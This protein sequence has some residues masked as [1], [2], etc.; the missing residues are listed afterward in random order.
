MDFSERRK[1]ARANLELPRLGV[2]CAAFGGLYNPVSLDD[3]MGV[4][5]QAWSA[6]I[7][8]F[9]TAPMYG[10][11]RAE[12]LL[13][14]F[15]R[16]CIDDASDTVI[17]T[18]A[19]RLMTRDRP[20]RNLPPA[21]PKNPL[22]PGWQ[23][24]LGFREV[25]DYSYDG[26]MRSFDDSQQRLGRPEIDLLYV[27]DIGRVTHAD[28][29]DF[30]WRALTSSGFRALEELR[31]AGLIKGFGLGVNEAEAISDAMN[32]VQLDCCLLAGRY[33]L[34]D[35][36][37]APLLAKAQA[38]GVS[39]VCGGVYNSGIL[40]GTGAGQTKFDYAEAPSAILQTVERLASL[41]ASHDVPLGAAA[42]QFPLRNP[43]VTS[44][45]VGARTA[46]NVTQGLDWFS[47]AIPEALWA[48]LEAES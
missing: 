1:I 45:V 22:D 31:S 35:R 24:G 23:N 40:A 39:I 13:G 43:V 2:G 29:H 18:K 12:H 28:L 36:S 33:T 16:E 11:G 3:A 30:H 34:L 5:S 21:P 42:V 19:G 9:D 6:G 27:H 8:Y 17:S 15:L 20:G 14:H 25:F 41:C 44:V 32:E 38:N 48:E 4:L 46:A 47:Q 26:I 10:L 7:R 37:A